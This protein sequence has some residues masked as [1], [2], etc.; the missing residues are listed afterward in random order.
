MGKMKN[1]NRLNIRALTEDLWSSVYEKPKPVITP[2]G[3][4]SNADTPKSNVT[5][6]NDP[7]EDVLAKN[8]KIFSERGVKVN[9]VITPIKD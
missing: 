3:T 1:M 9:Q 4:Y 5:K 6:V 7:I 2:S 8:K